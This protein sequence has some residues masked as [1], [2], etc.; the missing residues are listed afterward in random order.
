MC[1]SQMN[2]LT[3]QTP[4]REHVLLLFFITYL[5][6]KLIKEVECKPAT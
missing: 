5:S 1:H 2:R 6:Y 3:E 4:I